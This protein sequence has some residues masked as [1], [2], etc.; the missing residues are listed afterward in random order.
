MQNLFA[1][2]APSLLT[3]I[4]AFLVIA[5]LALIVFSSRHPNGRSQPIVFLRLERSFARLARRKRLSMLLVGLSV[6]AIRVALLPILGVPGPFNHDEFSYLLAAD[7]FAHGRLTNPT[8]PMWI[9]FESF[10]IFQKPTYMSMYPPAEGLVLAAG[11]LVGHPW[12]GQLLV[13]ALMCSA[14]CWMLQAWLPP[15]WALFGAVLAALRL[16]ILSYWMN[17]YWSASVVALAGALMLGA[18][19]RLRRRLRVRYAVLI[20]LGLVIL[21]NSR[22]YEGLLFALPLAFAMLFWLLGKNHPAFSRSLP[23]IILP[24]LACLLA[25]AI[26][27]GC[28]YYRVTGSPFRMAYQVNYTTYGRAPYF[29]W[30]TPPPEPAY[31][32]KVMRDFYRLDFSEFEKQLTVSGYLRSTSERIYS[33]WQFYLGPLLTLPLLALPFVIRRKKMRLPVAICITTFAGF[34]VQTWNSPHYFSPATGALYILLVQCVRQL[35]YWRRGSTAAAQ[36]LVRTIPVLACAMILL[37]IT[38]AAVHVQ[39]ELAWP[40][41][42]L[43]R[44]LV[45]HQLQSLPGKQL[46]IV[47]YAPWHDLAEEW[48][49]ND[50]DI[51]ASKVAWARDMGKDGNRDLVQYFRARNIWKVNGDDPVPQAIPYPD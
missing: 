44:A 50:A 20:G 11:Q 38:A 32:H 49:Y 5:T 7:T 6:I 2:L 24:I 28:Y 33:W 18:W 43:E 47:D 3:I 4:E 36:A 1:R 42:N 25:G 14:L 26:A 9:H 22:P 45:L 30:Q 37:R 34:A 27:S 41:G 21:A 8:H 19:P 39:I 23:R 40:R 35:W 16:G 17:G 10:H 29:L 48:V 12:I 51:D 46:V 13:T 15:P 31:R